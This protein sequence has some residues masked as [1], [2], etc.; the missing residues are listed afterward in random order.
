MSQIPSQ[1]TSMD[2]YKYT[3]NMKFDWEKWLPK[4]FFNIIVLSLRNATQVLLYKWVTCSHL[5]QHYVVR[6]P[7]ASFFP[8]HPSSISFGSTLLLQDQENPKVDL[9]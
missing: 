6:K 5:C 8:E 4:K 3:F 2:L 7:N 1:M 9:A